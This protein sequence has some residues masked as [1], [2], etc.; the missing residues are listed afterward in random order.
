MIAEQ[1]CLSDP[2]MFLN[3]SVTNRF[4]ENI[5]AKPPSVQISTAGFCFE[6]CEGCRADE[7]DRRVIEDA[8]IE[9]DQCHVCSK[10]GG[11]LFAERFVFGFDIRALRRTH[12]HGWR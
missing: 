9:T 10:C 7:R 11:E 2:G 1:D 6:S 4:D 12:T 5:G 3:G 8:V